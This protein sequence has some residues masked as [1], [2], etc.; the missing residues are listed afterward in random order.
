LLRGVELIGRAFPVPAEQGYHSGIAVTGLGM[1]EG[2]GGIRASHESNRLGF[3]HSEHLSL[4]V[5]RR[6]LAR[7][8]RPSRFNMLRQ[9]RVMSV[10]F[11]MS[12]TSLVYLR[13]RKDCG[14]AANRR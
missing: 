14:S 10:V 5:V 13:L 9:L 4:V 6:A 11:A 3:S 12:A 2:L 7:C 8:T 1:I